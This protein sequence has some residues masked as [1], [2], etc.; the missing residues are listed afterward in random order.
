M[1][2]GTENGKC[3]ER[4][5]HQNILV[6]ILWGHM[7][8]NG[9]KNRCTNKKEGVQQSLRVKLQQSSLSTQMA[10]LMAQS[11]SSFSVLWSQAQKKGTCDTAQILCEWDTAQPL[12]NMYANVCFLFTDN[13]A[14]QGIAMKTRWAR[15]AIS[16]QSSLGHPKQSDKIF[17]W[18]EACAFKWKDRKRLW[19]SKVHHTWILHT[20][21]G[22][23]YVWTGGRVWIQNKLL[24][25]H[26]TDSKCQ[27]D[28]L[29]NKDRLQ[30]FSCT[31]H[32]NSC[33]LHS[34]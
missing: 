27:C 25:V 9:H 32:L 28:G 20:L 26:N 16:L 1:H 2:F 14:E 15:T 19:W 23:G 6:G 10:V 5:K 4:G 24:N 29:A 7:G 17:C 30:V 33:K 34:M 8:Q 13:A 31:T 22:C 18:H 21:F 12:H 3:T 11:R